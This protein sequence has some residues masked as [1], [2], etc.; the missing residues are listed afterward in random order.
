MIKVVNMKCFEI[1]VGKENP[2]IN[3]LSTTIK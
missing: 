2:K 1:G 3:I